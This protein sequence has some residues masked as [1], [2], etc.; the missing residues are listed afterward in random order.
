MKFGSDLFGM[1]QPASP[2]CHLL[3]AL[4][5]V[6]S[7]PTCASAQA[8]SRNTY[9]NFSDAY[10]SY[11]SAIESGDQSSALKAGRAAYDLGKAQFGPVSPNA[12]ALA[13]NLG[14]L[15]VLSGTDDALAARLFREADSIYEELNG[16]ASAERI[17]ALLALAAI[18]ETHDEKL[19]S[20]RALLAMHQAVF[21]HDKL[22][23]AALQ[24]HCGQ[25]LA[26]AR[27]GSLQAQEILVEALDTL[28]AELGEDSPELIATLFALGS[29]ASAW[30]AP[31]R[32]QKGYF[33]R[34]VAIANQ[35][36]SFGPEAIADLQTQIAL[37]LVRQRSGYREAMPYARAALDTYNRLFGAPHPKTAFAMLTLG[38][39]L[40][41]TND[42][43]EGVARIREAISF[44]ES[45]PEYAQSELRARQ[46]LM[47][48]YMKEGNETRYDEQLMEVA[49]LSEGST[50]LDDYLP[51]VR[52][53]PAYPMEAAR[54]GI[55]GYVIVQYTV[56]ERGRTRDVVV[57][58]SGLKPGKRG[59]SNIF[60]EAAIRSAERYRYLPRFEN[61]VPVSVPNVTTRIEF[62]MDD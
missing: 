3:V 4:A 59:K 45:S 18:Q 25:L 51:L 30:E 27:P 23:F 44:Y 22:G 41:G 21:P 7:I 56:D 16:A 2:I 35:T 49:R 5:V 60:D 39:A 29:A 6:T 26:D 52:A 54:D 47:T 34:A 55:E 31:D 58:E 24:T 37:K 9:K 12:A 38:Q 19:E 50:T 46:V 48:V 20:I 42:I 61:G 53:E 40:I 62:V 13:M 32:R 43:P 36:P 1:R 17:E 33:D 15:L 57:L 28:E 10:A 8:D 14:N 11:T